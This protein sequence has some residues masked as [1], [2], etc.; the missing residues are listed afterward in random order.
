MFLS[1]VP[2]EIRST[3]MAEIPSE[4]G[5]EQAT[6]CGGVGWG[7]AVASLPEGK[8]EG[9]SSHAPSPHHS[10]SGV[11]FS[12]LVHT[13]ANGMWEGLGW[14]PSLRC[15]VERPSHHPKYKVSL[16]GYLKLTHG[17]GYCSPNLQVESEEL[18]FKGIRKGQA[19]RQ[20]LTLS[21]EG[22]DFQGWF[23]GRRGSKLLD[24]RR[25]PHVFLK[26]GCCFQLAY[27]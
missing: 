14:P 20:K 7:R 12:V 17:A 24:T 13:G 22:I 19:D 23:R 6:E 16:K 5:A 26:L 2:K 21:A 4:L 25:E 3:E 15:G 1:N 27:C 11:G 9:S 8:S 18:W 10:W